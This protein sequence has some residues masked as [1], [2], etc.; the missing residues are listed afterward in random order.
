MAGVHNACPQSQKVR[1]WQKN[2]N[3]QTKSIKNT[4]KD[5]N[6]YIDTLLEAHKAPHLKTIARY[7]LYYLGKKNKFSVK[8]HN[9]IIFY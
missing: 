1:I 8:I 9:I 6:N 3:I 2:I 5:K 7:I 4:K